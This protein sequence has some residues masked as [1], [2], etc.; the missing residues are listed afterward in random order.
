[1]ATA[2][3]SAAI[4]LEYALDIREFELVKAPVVGHAGVVEQY[5]EASVGFEN[6]VAH[7]LQLVVVGDI[8][9]MGGDRLLVMRA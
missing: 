8:E 3:D 2:N 6:F 4:D 9:L 7:A 1:M 5:V